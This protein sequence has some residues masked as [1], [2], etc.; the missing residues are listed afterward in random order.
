MNLIAK[1]R[2]GMDQ[3]VSVL[4]CYFKVYMWAFSNIIENGKE[5]VWIL[6]FLAKEIEFFFR[7]QIIRLNIISHKLKGNASQTKYKLK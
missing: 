1:A 6:D 3:E 4:Y 2:L 5:G 7:N